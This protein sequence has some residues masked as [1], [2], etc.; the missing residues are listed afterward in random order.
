MER[1]ELKRI[2]RLSLLNGE[3]DPLGAAERALLD[4][5]GDRIEV[6]RVHGNFSYASA[7]QLTRALGGILRGPRAVVFDFSAAGD[8]NTSA[9]H[10]IGEL[11]DDAQTAGAAVYLAALSGVAERTLSGPGVLAPVPAAHVKAA[12]AEV[13]PAAP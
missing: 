3:T 11:V 9:A 4:S 10:A 5:A 6:V 7:R 13:A 12:L 8:V 2:T 1:E